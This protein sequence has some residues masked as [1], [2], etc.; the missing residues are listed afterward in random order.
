EKKRRSFLA[1]Q[2]LLNERASVAAPA[3][4]VA[5]SSISDPATLTWLLKIIESSDEA[6]IPVRE[7]CQE[8]FRDLV[9]RDLIVIRAL[10]RRMLIG[11][12]AP[13]AS[14]GNADPALLGESETLLWKPVH[15]NFQNNGSPTIPDELIESVAKIRLQRSERLLPGLYRA[16]R[17]RVAKR[18]TDQAY[19]NRLNSQLKILADRI[20]KRWPNAFLA[21]EEL[22]EE[23]IQFT[24]TG[25][26]TARMIAGD[27]ISDPIGWVDALSVA[28]I[29]DPSLPLMLEACRQPRPNLPAPPPGDDDLWRRIYDRAEGNI[30]T[31]VE[32]AIKADGFLKAT[33]AI[34]SCKSISQV[35]QGR[36]RDWY[37]LSTMEHRW[38][39][40]PNSRY[41]AADVVAQRF[42]TLE[43]RNKGDRVA[44]TLPPIAAGDI[45]M[46]TAIEGGYVSSSL[47][48][49]QPLV[50]LDHKL[51][52]LGDS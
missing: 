32:E 33:I 7:A 19:K 14:P 18:L 46:W 36:F 45:E 17:E 31:S 39:K 15:M 23:V 44:F 48:K 50:G 47:D 42:Q 6:S 38:L 41:D 4:K 27:P 9:R 37:W 2:L 13:I 12:Q 24:A 5:L 28:L 1:A 40:P 10:A 49:S 43:I 22:V 30:T 26:R 34:K 3:F 29:D 51:L 52:L 35:E 20:G 16:T 25:G 11:E 21:S 8:I